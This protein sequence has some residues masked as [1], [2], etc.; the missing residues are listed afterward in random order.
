MSNLSEVMLARV[1][2]YCSHC[3]VKRK[4]SLSLAV[5]PRRADLRHL[6]LAQARTGLL[7]DHDGELE[8]APRQEEETA[9]M[10]VLLWNVRRA[11]LR[12]EGGDAGAVGCKLFGDRRSVNRAAQGIG[13]FSTNACNN[14][15]LSLSIL[16]IGRGITALSLG[17]SAGIRCGF[18][19]DWLFTNLWLDVLCSRQLNAWLFSN[20][21][22]DVLIH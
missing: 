14:L 2:E 22:L 8:K 6:R 11:T 20:D 7:G 19:T 18:S 10:Q 3:L 5:R 17:V 21:W 12:K 16:W 9:V 13:A 1:F 15:R 4:N